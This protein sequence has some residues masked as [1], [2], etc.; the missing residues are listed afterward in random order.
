MKSVAWLYLSTLQRNLSDKIDAFLALNTHKRSTCRTSLKL[1]VIKIN[2]K[3][4]KREK[5]S[6]TYSDDRARKEITRNAS[7]T[8]AK[9]KQEFKNRTAIKLVKKTRMRD[10]LTIDRRRCKLSSLFLRIWHHSQR[11]ERRKKLVLQLGKNTVIVRTGFSGCVGRA[12]TYKHLIFR[13]NNYSVHHSPSR[14]QRCCFFSRTQLSK[15]CAIIDSQIYAL[16][17]KPRRIVKHPLIV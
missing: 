9:Y 3:A 14:L 1:L 17:A 15:M 4:R 2:D 11:N 12:F 6:L 8:N 7:R 13:L 16:R 10:S 5:N